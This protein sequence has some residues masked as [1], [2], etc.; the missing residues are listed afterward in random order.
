MS[1]GVWYTDK[2]NSVFV[3]VDKNVQRDAKIQTKD[4]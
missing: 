3:K 1:V 4:Q 2:D